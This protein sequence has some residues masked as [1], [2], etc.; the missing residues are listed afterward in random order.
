LIIE[1][2]DTDV[3]IIGSGLAGLVAAIEARKYGA[4]VIL[5]SKSLTG[6]ANCSAFSGGTF[7]APLGAF[8]KESHFKTTMV[9]GRHINN[10]KLV[11]TLVNEA[12]YCVFKL[13]EWGVKIAVGDGCCRVVEGNFPMKG[14]EAVNPLVRLVKGI[15]IKTLESIM[16]IDLLSDEKVNGAIAFN[17]HNGKRICISAK[18]VVLATGGAGQVYYRNDNPVR[19]TGDGY[20]IAFNL[21]LPLIDMEFVQFWPIGSAEPGYPMFYLEPPQ[22]FLESGMLQNIKGEDIAEKYRLNPKLVYSVQRD[23]W[24]KAIAMEIH[25]GRGDGDAVLLNFTKLPKSLK[26]NDFI[27]FL[28]KIFKESPILTNPLH[29]SPLAHHFMGGIIID[30]KCNTAIPGIF[31]AGEVTGGLHGANRLGGNALTECLVFGA[32]AGR[33]AAEY[34]KVKPKKPVDETQTKQKFKRIDAIAAM[35]I[36]EHGNPKTVKEKIQK[37]MWEKA[38][39]IRTQQGLIG[40]LEDLRQLKEENI[41]SL[42]GRKAHEIMEAIE[43]ENLLTV[44]NLILMAALTRTESR[45]AHY[46]ID[47]SDQDDKNWLKHV[48]LTK[49]KEKIEIST[50]KLS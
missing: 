38:G 17:V 24:A 49:K 26:E 12:A 22:L 3:L 7:T 15:G 2:V 34:A 32:R 31:A 36:S 29:V 9:A 16:I 45:G 20:A 1:I 40:A 23:A 30:E 50:C 11:K 5:A 35:E 44:A 8:S 4:E 18:A 41:P 27:R 47:Y 46:R 10:Q 39:L 28:S 25:E 48:I 14:A 21:G 43:V 42:Y 13:K 19:T 37:V 6:F 33:Y